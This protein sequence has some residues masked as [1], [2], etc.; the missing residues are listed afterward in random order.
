MKPILEDVTGFLGVGTLEILGIFFILDG[1]YGFLSFIE[2]IP[3]LQLG[4]F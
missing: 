1:A 2:Y 4:R 3:K